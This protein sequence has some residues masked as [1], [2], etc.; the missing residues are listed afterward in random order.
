MKAKSLFVLLAAVISMTIHAQ[1]AVEDQSIQWSIDE[2]GTLTIKGQSSMKDYAEWKTPWEYFNSN[3]KTVIIE[4]GVTGIGAYAFS[5]CSQITFVVLP[6]SLQSIG[7]HAFYNCEKLTS[8]TIPNSVTSIGA[9]AFSECTKLQSAILSAELQ[10]IPNGMFEN[11]KSLQ[12][13]SI[14]NKV[15]RIGKRAF[16]SCKALKDCIIPLEVGA[17]GEQAF[18]ECASLKDI[19]VPD[20]VTSIENETFFK[21]TSLEKVVMGNSLR[22]IGSRAF[23]KCPRLTDV[24]CLATSVPRAETNAFGKKVKMINLYV[25]NTRYYSMHDYWKNF[26]LRGENK[27]EMQI[28]EPAVIVNTPEETIAKETPKAPQAAPKAPQAAPTKAYTV[29]ASSVLNVRSAA[30]PNASVLGGVRSG[31]TVYV[32]NIENGSW[33]K[34]QY[35]GRS[36]YVSTK[37]IKEKEAE[38]VVIAQSAMVTEVAAPQQTETFVAEQP[39]PANANTVQKSKGPAFEMYYDFVSGYVGGAK[40]HKVF[41]KKTKGSTQGG[42]G[43]DFSLGVRSSSRRNYFGAGLG[44]HAVFQKKLSKMYMPIYATD[45]FFFST[46]EGTHSFFEANIGGFVNLMYEDAKN[47]RH[48]GM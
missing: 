18:K 37:F 1:N 6:Q 47:N 15:T 9:Y 38:Q 14:P 19:I 26:Q 41:G 25:L 5:H 43:G 11:C 16:V 22:Y 40:G 48:K 24:Q 30:S 36:G 46:G 7:H 4:E 2:K 33:A 10:E 20:K 34:I 8:I 21:C 44:L 45:K 32:E 35:N 3:I 12:A 28:E 13:I 31:E 39:K 23:D 42:I 17:I 27:D 29:T